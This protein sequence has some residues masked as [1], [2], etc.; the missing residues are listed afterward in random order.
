MRR[1]EFMT[2]LGGTA[3]TWPLVA[4]GQQQARPVVGFLCSGSPITDASRIAAVRR[5]LQQAGY[6]EGRNITIEYRWA[7]SHYDRLTALAIELA[8]R[9]V[10]VI[11]AIGTTP[12][13]VAAKTATN[14][15]PTVFVIGADPVGLGLVASLNRPGGNRTG[16]SF[17][18]RIIVPKQFEILHEVVV[19][20]AMLSSFLVSPDIPFAD[21]DISD[22]RA[23]AR[24]LG[25]DLLVV[26]ATTEIEIDAAFTNLVQQRVGSLLVAGDLFLNG[27]QEQIIALAARHAIA[28]LYPWREATINGGLMS[29]GADMADAFR[30]AGIYVGRILSGDKPADLPV[31]QATKIELVINLKTAKAPWP[32]RAA[33]A[34]GARRRG[35][36]ITMLFAAVHMA[37]NG[38]FETRHPLR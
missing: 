22:V 36:R 28:V 6:D 30:L 27:H 11:V 10:S 20:K 5:G 29:Y 15:V 16:V 38:T 33:R 26:K 1:R 13:A 12:A 18:N 21:A 34:G 9:K 35:D 14:L 32:Q 23:A 17:L 19:S 24:T 3:A 37:A 2:L 25:Q 7:E 8:Q 4:R 31:Q